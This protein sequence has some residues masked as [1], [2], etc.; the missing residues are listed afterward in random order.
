ML[1]ASR[2][3]IDAHQWS[4]QQSPMLQQCGRV[5]NWVRVE[6]KAEGA[7]GP[8]PQDSQNTFPKDL[9]SAAA[10]SLLPRNNSLFSN[11]ENFKLSHGNDGLN[12]GSASN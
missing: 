3:R 11:L 4:P 6:N 2:S 12:L 8:A 9:N 7:D 10:P 1:A 5:N